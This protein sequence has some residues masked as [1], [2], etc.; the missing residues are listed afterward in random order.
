MGSAASKSTTTLKLID[1]Y[2]P[3]RGESRTPTMDERKLDGKGI[4]G[5]GTS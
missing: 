5:S 3:H 2:R 1:N 4:Y